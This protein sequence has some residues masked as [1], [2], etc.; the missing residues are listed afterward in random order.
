[1][2]FQPPASPNFKSLLFLG[3]ISKYYLREIITKEN[4]KLPH[5]RAS[6]LVALQ[7]LEAVIGH[8]TVTTG[9]W[10]FGV[11]LLAL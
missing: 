4:K 8:G 6:D 11:K 10:C 1:M 2:T 7:A 9:D 5:V 3:K